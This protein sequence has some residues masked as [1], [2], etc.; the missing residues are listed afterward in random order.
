M[1]Q[2][3]CSTHLGVCESHFNYM[4]YEFIQRQPIS[5]K[6]GHHLGRGNKPDYYLC[7]FNYI[8]NIVIIHIDVFPLE[9]FV[10]HF[11]HNIVDSLL[12]TH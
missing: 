4:L 3:P 1:Y 8:L 5:Q 9:L 2:K 12:K 6:S 7:L 11:I 10:P